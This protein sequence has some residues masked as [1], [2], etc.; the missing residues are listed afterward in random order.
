M[1]CKTFLSDKFE[2]YLACFTY[3]VMQPWL[4]LHKFTYSRLILWGPRVKSNLSESC[5]V[6]KV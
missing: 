1:D 6:L 2:K 4:L 5:V 3:I